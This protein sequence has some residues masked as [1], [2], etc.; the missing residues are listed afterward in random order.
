MKTKEHVVAFYADDGEGTYDELVIDFYNHY[1][2]FNSKT[3]EKFLYGKDNTVPEIKLNNEDLH[4]IFDTIKLLYSGKIGP[5]AYLTKA[6]F[7]EMESGKPVIDKITLWKAIKRELPKKELDR[8]ISF[9]YRYEKDDYYDFKLIIDGIYSVMSGDISVDYFTSWLI[10]LMRCLDDNILKNEKIKD[11]YA[12]LANYFDG[13]AFMDHCIG[14]KKKL[15][16]CREII[17]IVKYANHKIENLKKKKLTDFTT[18]NVI[19]YISFGF[20]LDDGNMCIDRV[21][22]VDKKRKRINYMYI[23]EIDYREDINYTLLPN[24]EFDD[25]PSRYVKGYKLDSSMT[26]DYAVTK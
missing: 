22:V 18:N 11:E 8:I 20:S 6:D 17:A 15:I 7:E 12:E 3:G 2:D 24:A 4:K 13:F 5:A 10:L 1:Y 14:K 9:D 23:K 21:C 25:L 19:T 26:A 16:E